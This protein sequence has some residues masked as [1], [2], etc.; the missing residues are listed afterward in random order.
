VL[1]T[2]QVIYEHIEDTLNKALAL[3]GRVDEVYRL[4]GPRVRRLANQCFFDK[5][6][7]SAEDE[8]P[9]GY[10]GDLA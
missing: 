5:L 1:D 2:A 3:V 9:R 4:G 6:L 8:T 10:R 7:I